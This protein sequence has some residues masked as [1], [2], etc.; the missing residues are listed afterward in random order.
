MGEIGTAAINGTLWFYLGVYFGMSVLTCIIG[1]LRYA[2]IVR[3]SIRASRNLFDKLTY[4]VLR[5]P[6]RW[7]DTV[8]VGRILN[9]FTADFNMIDSKLAYDFGFMLYN[10][11][12]VLG[13]VVAGLLVSPILII[14]A[15]LLLLICFYYS[16][17]FLSGTLW[18]GGHIQPTV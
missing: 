10:I 13:I 9:R 2:L 3:A 6:L 18:T 14:F 17:L 16:Q 5:A 15:I 7:L 4:A 12:Q 8:P 11:F 1:S